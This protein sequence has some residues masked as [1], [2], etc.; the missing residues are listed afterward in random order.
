MTQQ[1]QSHS[2]QDQFGLSRQAKAELAA[3]PCRGVSAEG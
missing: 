2:L 3:F 1:S